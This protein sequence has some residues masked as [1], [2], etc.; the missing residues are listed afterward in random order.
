MIKKL[1]AETRKNR[2]KDRRVV[3]HQLPRRMRK[4]E[5]FWWGGYCMLKKG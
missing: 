3:S 1:A 4:G 5:Y 2:S